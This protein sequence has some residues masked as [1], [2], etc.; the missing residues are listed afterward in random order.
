[1]SDHYD[2][3]HPTQEWRVVDCKPGKVVPNPKGAGSLQSYYVTLEGVEDGFT[4]SD[5]CWWRRKAGNE[6][7]QGESVYG[8]VSTNDYGYA[9]RLEQRDGSQK[10]SQPSSP[11]F[12]AAA[13]P[14]PTGESQDA[15]QAS[16]VRQHSD[17][18]ALRFL[19][20][21][22]ADGEGHPKLECTPE[23]LEVNLAPISDWFFAHA[24]GQSR[25]QVSKPIGTI[26][27]PHPEDDDIPFA[28][29]DYPELFSG[30]ERGSHGR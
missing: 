21:C 13:G 7:Q 22:I 26:T 2:P 23:W 24:G 16:I 20:S 11:A 1:M 10:P 6:P 30:V 18:M 3:P 14:P 12:R 29:P 8:T 5:R 15:R 4:P 27:K 17:E 19:A 28:R 25:S 9:F